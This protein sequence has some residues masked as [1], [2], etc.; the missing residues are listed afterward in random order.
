MCLFP[1]L[2]KNPKYKP[3]KKNN[4]N[5]PP[6]AEYDENGNIIRYIVDQRV[7]WVPI[8]CGNCIECR[9]QKARQWQVRLNEEKKQYTHKYCLTLT[10]SNEE[11]EAL[12]KKYN[13]KECN[14]VATKAMRMFLERWR[15]Q[16]KK[17][18]RHW[19]VTEL[20]HEN[21][22]RIH[23]HGIIFSNDVIDEETFAKYWK[24]G[25][26][27]LGSWLGM[28]TIN[29][30][31]KYVH[32]IDT[33]HKDFM[34]VV[35]CSNGIGNNYT[36]RLSIKKIHSFDNNTIEYYRLENGTKINLPIYY[37]NKL[38]NEKQRED[39]WLQRLDKD[40]R[41][42]MGIKI[43]NFSSLEGQEKYKRILKTAQ[44]TNK[45]LGFG[46]LSKEWQKKDYNVTLRMLQRAKK[47]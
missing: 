26:I 14:A 10:F 27:R 42:V 9:K 2:I 3:T 13:L 16:Y 29:Y 45:L 19:F 11:L 5:P 44:R 43:S 24:Y 15:K 7:M 30:L 20:G 39:L 41:F 37:R 33:L 34:P 35:L 17:S 12:C 46:D 25:N 28:K 32:K 40:E 4:Y 36:Q 22:E 21:T 6:I 38:W 23:M 47:K 1:R 31:I 18:L 8:G